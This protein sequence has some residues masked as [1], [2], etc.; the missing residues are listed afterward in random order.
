MNAHSCVFL[1]LP[2]LLWSYKL[3]LTTD[4]KFESVALEVC[5]S[6]IAEVGLPPSLQ[7]TG[8]FHVLCVCDS[9]PSLRPQIKEC[10]EEERG[11]GYLV[12]CLVDHRGNI[13]EYQCNQYV[14][15]MTSIVFSDYRL[16]CGFMDK[17][18]E[19]IN[20]LHCGSINVG[21]KVSA[22]SAGGGGLQ[23]H[24][25]TIFMK[26]FFYSWIFFFFTEMCFLLPH[27]K[28]KH[29]KMSTYFPHVKEFLQVFLN[30]FVTVK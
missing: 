26:I 30:V 3:N 7:S 21:Q 12:S 8:S 29:V 10:N 25:N 15:K 16:I 18:K 27:L 23:L 2:Q 11:R 17:C 24:T 28:I 20:Q 1:S 6:T 5:K 4:P 14:T 22:G 13:S 9:S 19:D